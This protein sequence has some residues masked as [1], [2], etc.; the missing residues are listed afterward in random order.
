MARLA[1]I[2]RA[3][4]LVV[5]VS[6]AEEIPQH[7][8]SPTPIEPMEGEVCESPP[9]YTDHNKFIDSHVF[10]FSESAKIGDS[11]DGENIIPM[12]VA[13]DQSQNLKSQ[14]LELESTITPRRIR[15]VLLDKQDAQAW[16]QNVENQISDL[17]LQLQQL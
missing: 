5:N 1:I 15:D 4:N 10:V 14:I 6:E 7:M 3:T 13:V 2:E 8:E 17:R 11:W 16:L 9:D 12:E